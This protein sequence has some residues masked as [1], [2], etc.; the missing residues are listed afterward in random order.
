MQMRILVKF[1]V[2]HY[3]RPWAGMTWP[4]YAN[5][6]C[7][8]YFDWCVLPV[9][10]HSRTGGPNGPTS[11]TLPCIFISSLLWLPLPVEHYY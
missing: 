4:D 7:W 9:P 2:E 3:K 1:P 8:A 10:D 5:G 11:A 6:L